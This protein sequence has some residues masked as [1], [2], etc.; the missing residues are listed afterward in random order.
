M[1]ISLHVQIMRQAISPRLAIRIFLNFLI[2]G[3]I[4]GPKY[5][6]Q[7]PTPFSSWRTLDLGPWT[8]ELLLKSEQR[9]AILN[10]LSIFNVNLRDFASGLGLNFIHQLHRLDNANHGFGLDAGADLHKRLG[11]RRR[12][13]IKGP[14]D[15]RRNDVKVLIFGGFRLGFRSRMDWCGGGRQFGFDD[16]TASCR[17]YG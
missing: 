13:S 10:R 15:R 8:F 2:S 3:F 6:V 16:W 9:L 5:N 7:C 4:F 12:G 11:I 17:R 1:S 14:D